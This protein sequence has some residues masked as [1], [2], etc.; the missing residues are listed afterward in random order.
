MADIECLTANDIDNSV[1]MADGTPL[2]ATN[3]VHDADNNVFI[4]LY[5]RNSQDTLTSFV[6]DTNK[7]N[8]S[9]PNVLKYAPQLDKSSGL[10][11]VA[12]PANGRN[13]LYY[14]PAGDSSFLPWIHTY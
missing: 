13:I 11:V 6:Y 8:W 12:D 10:S 2:A 5:C 4:Y 1:G 14:L 3:V 7:Q 9:G